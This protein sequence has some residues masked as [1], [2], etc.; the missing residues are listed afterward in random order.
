MTLI[1]LLFSIAPLAVAPS[2]TPSLLLGDVL[3]PGLRSPTNST[4]QPSL[5][6]LSPQQTSPSFNFQK[7]HWDNFAFYFDTHCP[8]A[9]EY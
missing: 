2:L 6:S 4:N 1:Y 8:S 7:A 3:R 5:S 9:E